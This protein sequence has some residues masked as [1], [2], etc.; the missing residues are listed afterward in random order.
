MWVCEVVGIIHDG[1]SVESCVYG[2]E[3]EV[4]CLPSGARI[5]YKAKNQDGGTHP[6]PTPYIH[7]LLDVH[8]EGHACD[9]NQPLSAPGQC[10]LERC[11]RW[12]LDACPC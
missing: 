12:M 10:F 11:W 5:K 9:S 6:L 7:G 8:W 1:V 3:R 4:A 2:A